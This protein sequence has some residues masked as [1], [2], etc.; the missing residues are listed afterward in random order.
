MARPVVG[1]LVRG[2]VAGLAA[3]VA[4]APCAVLAAGLFATAADLE[5]MRDPSGHAAALR[6]DLADRA[7][8]AAA[9]VP[10][11]FHAVDMS[12]IRFGW[13]EP[14][15]PPDDTLREAVDRLHRDTDRMRTLALDAALG[16]PRAHADAAVAMMLA[17]AERHTPV[18]VYD[19]NPDFAAAALEGGTDGFESDRPWNFGLDAIW[20][21]YGLMNAADAWLLLRR[22]GHPFEPSEAA[23]IR[24]WL[25]RLTE[26][27]NSG[28]HAWTRWADANA[29]G[30]AAFHATSSTADLPSE[31]AGYVRHRS[32][33]HLSWALAG[34]LAG[35][36]ALEDDDLAAYVLDGG[37]W[38]DRRAGAYA[39]PSPIG[40]VI[41]RAV[42]ADG[43]MF[44][45]TI[46]RSPRIAYALFHLE[47][48][49]LAAR[50]AAVHYDRDV[51]SLQGADGA[52]MLDAF[53]RY[54]PYARGD[55]PSPDPAETGGVA[56][57]WLFALSPPGYGGAERD[58]LRA[59]RPV[60]LFMS[61]A[62]GPARLLAER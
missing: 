34:L 12:A 42:G 33:N 26:A 56:G 36:V 10:E 58:R 62:V 21:A 13:R 2:A 11:P 14:A 47:A 8:A 53:R 48:M 4:T 30:G 1:L 22:Q 9:A 46:E 19:F 35:A 38:R 20:Q 51:W 52:G 7:E 40:A 59:A 41:D 31:S 44:E 29:G 16:G 25:L 28:F 43:T 23:R 5:R 15:E 49:S 18:N 32:D 45:E 54:A 39:N 61:H 60:D 55:R 17:W 27:V 57:R 3:A 37:V 6:A 50:M 24:D